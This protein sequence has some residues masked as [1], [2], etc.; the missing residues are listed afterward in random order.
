MFSVPGRF[1]FLQVLF[2]SVALFSSSVTV[3]GYRSTLLKQL[4]LFAEECVP[5]EFCGNAATPT[6]IR[7]AANSSYR[8]PG[9]VCD[10]VA[11]D[12]PTVGHAVADTSRRDVARGVRRLSQVWQLVCKWQE[13]IFIKFVKRQPWKTNPLNFRIVLLLIIKLPY[14][15]RAL[16]YQIRNLET[17]KTV[18][19]RNWNCALLGYC[20][21][22]SDN[23]F[24]TFRKTLSVP[25][26]KFKNPGSNFVP[27][28]LDWISWNVD[29]KLPLLGA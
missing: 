13:G 7:S 14:Y 29:K 8:G 21:A 20:A 15:K 18:H 22:S 26:S 12:E 3:S 16:N 19:A 10:G 23:F 9:C 25:Y 4:S 28:F 6:G 1:L 24:L 17:V 5:V 27:T 11:G 2:C